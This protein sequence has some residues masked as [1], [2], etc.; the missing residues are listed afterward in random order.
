MTTAI[1]A[2]SAIPFSQIR[3][4]LE[5]AATAKLSDGTSLDKDGSITLALT[6]LGDIEH[7]VQELQ[8]WTAEGQQFMADPEKTGVFFQLA[9][10]WSD[11]PW[12][13]KA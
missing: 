12:R 13:Q 2:P 8:K 4:A 3:A 10:W 5:T 1:E 7:Y 9:T 6:N 11:R